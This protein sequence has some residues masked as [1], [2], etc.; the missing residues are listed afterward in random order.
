MKEH[1]IVV[2]TKINNEAQYLEEW[3][4]FYIAQGIKL[5]FVYD[6]N[7]NDNPKKVLQKYINKGIVIYKTIPKNNFDHIYETAKKYKDNIEWLAPVDLDEF[8]HPTN[9]KSLIQNIQELDAKGIGA[10]SV[11]WR[12][13]GSNGHVKNSFEPV[14]ERFTKHANPLY[15]LNFVTKCIIKVDHIV[16]GDTKYGSHRVNT[17][18]EYH[19]STGMKVVD[20][21]EKYR[22]Q[23]HKHYI[24]YQK[25]IYPNNPGFHVIRPWVV[26]PEPNATLV[27][28]HYKTKS[29]EEFLAK[30]SRFHHRFRYT[31]RIF[32]LY[33][34]HL[35]VISLKQ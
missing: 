8:I 17:T 34:L 22:Q 20:N 12:N 28:D 4:E 1:Y 24:C 6:D 5:F 21:Q 9:K 26:Y 2:S 15:G 13:F 19:T 25:E 23:I 30:A 32:D 35:N 10:I 33:Q 29:E 16:P 18:A 31:K 27:M 14:R 7:S 11:N 3:L